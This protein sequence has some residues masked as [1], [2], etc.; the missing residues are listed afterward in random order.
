MKMKKKGNE[1]MFYVSALIAIIGAVGYQF[2]VKRVP[3]S[4]NPVVS[5]IGVYIAVLIL[6][7]FLLPFFPSE[8]GLVKQFRQLNWVQLAI[9]AS[10]F[11]LELGFLLMYRYGWNLSTGNLITG[12]VINIALLGLGILVLGEKITFINAIGVIISIIGVALIGYR[13]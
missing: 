13:P 3:I 5:V 7:L 11:F 4:L 1:I 9:A 6:S 12:I 8:G 10:V 2:F